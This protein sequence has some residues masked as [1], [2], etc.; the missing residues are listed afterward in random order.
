MKEL[1][2]EHLQTN[3]K[4]YVFL[5][6][7]SYTVGKGL[8]NDIVLM[9]S[10]VPTHLAKIE[11]K[12]QKFVWIQNKREIDLSRSSL[13]SHGFRFKVVEH[14]PKFFILLVLFAL[15]SSFLVFQ[16]FTS[17][18]TVAATVQTLPAKGPFGNI[19]EQDH[20]KNVLFTFPTKAGLF[21]TLHYT[22]G[23]IAKESDLEI[24]INDHFLTFS[25]ISP[26]RWNVESKMFIP[27]SMLDK[28]D[29]QIEFRYHGAERNWGVKDIYVENGEDKPKTQSSAELLNTAEKF[30]HERNFKKG[31]LI[32]SIQILSKQKILLES[33]QKAL[34][35][36]YEKLLAD[37]LE[38]KH[39]LILDYTMAAQKFK[40][41]GYKDKAYKIYNK[42][43]L[44]LID[45]MDP[46]RTKILQEMR[47]PS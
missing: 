28:K 46:D 14:Q 34:P 47:E 40:E 1:I 31:N 25:P 44:E 45:P 12:D 41:G 19:G 7:L 11:K 33:K 43:L 16:H 6:S 37:A 32:R 29:N 4:R 9:D 42:L 20:I 39:Q 18:K 13:V 24:L 22:S 10:Q 35:G 27:Q 17:P 8:H 23:N 36:K 30:F 3:K 15:I 26:N 38:E 21:A 2:C 5:S